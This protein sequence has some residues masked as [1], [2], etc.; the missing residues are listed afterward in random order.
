MLVPTTAP[1]VKV[2]NRTVA[3][4]FA[5]LKGTLKKGRQTQT[6]HDDDGKEDEQEKSVRGGKD[7]DK[8]RHTQTH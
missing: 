3:V 2:N 8:V 1:I 6:S 7:K 5:A 4:C